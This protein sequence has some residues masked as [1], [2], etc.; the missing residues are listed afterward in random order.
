MP[1]KAIRKVTFI[2]MGI[3]GAPI[4]T[5]ILDAGYQLTVYNRTREK[6]Q[7]LIDRGAR[8]APDVQSAA[9]GADVVLTMLGYPQD[10]EEVYLERDG[11]IRSASKGAWMVDLTTSSPQ[12]ARDIHDAAEV[13]DKHAFDC[14]VTGGQQG[15]VEG[16]LTLMVGAAQKDVEPLVPLLS[17]FS[18]KVYYLGGP[19]RGQTV[20]LCNQISLALAMV[21]YAEALALADRSGIDQK[22]MLDVVSHGMGDTRALDDLAP[23]SL[24]ADYKPGFMAAHLRKDLGLAL[25]E[26]EDLGFALPG[27]EAANGLYDILCTVGGAQ[28]GTQ[29]LTLLY[30]DDETGAAAGLDWTRVDAHAHDHDA[31]AHDHDHA[32]EHGM[33]H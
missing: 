27:T 6:A 13:E 5:H 10:V 23:R 32:H 4:A 1:S 29:A 26:A 9:L 12:L 28:M 20:K 17:T 3:M 24:A 31:H 30:Q 25:E 8:W 11:L 7:P 21:G 14:P 16:T 2:G 19:G 15:A 22:V 18:S 33:D